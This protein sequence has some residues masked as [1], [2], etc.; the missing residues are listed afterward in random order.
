MLYLLDIHHRPAMV[1]LVT[2]SEEELRRVGQT[3]ADQVQRPLL[4]TTGPHAKDAHFTPTVP[5]VEPVLP[6]VPMDPNLAI[7]SE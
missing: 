5:K 1:V 7:K 3:Y 6:A 4:V 2:E